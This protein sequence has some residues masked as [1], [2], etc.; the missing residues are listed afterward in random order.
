MDIQSI[1]KRNLLIYLN[2]DELT[3]L[4]P[5]SEIKTDDAA[6]ILKKAIG[7]KTGEDEW[8]NVYLELFAGKNSMLLIARAHSGNPYFFEFQGIEDVIAAAETCAADVISFLAYC[9]GKYYLIVYPWDGEASPIALLEHG[10][11]LAVHANYAIHLTEHGKMLSG[12]AALDELRKRF[13]A[14]ADGER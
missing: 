2:G 3:D 7:N 8:S 10:S 14:D 1:G 13:C 6:G 12:P 11:E 4:P 5:P 9:E